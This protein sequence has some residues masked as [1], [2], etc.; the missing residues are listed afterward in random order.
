MYILKGVDGVTGLADIISHGVRDELV[1]YFLQFTAGYFTGDDVYHL[2]ADVLNL[3]V[4]GIGS[5]LC[6]TG[7]LFS[8]SHTEHT[9][10]VSV[11]GLDISV[12]LNQGL[13]R[14]IN[15]I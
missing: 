5:L 15:Q 4:L 7:H 3:H 12:A 6:L 9:E 8:E 13:E 1:Y 2:P 14:K 11:S 10:Q